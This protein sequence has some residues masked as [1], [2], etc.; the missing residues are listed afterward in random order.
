MTKLDSEQTLTQLECDNMTY[1]KKLILDI[2]IPNSVFKIKVEPF[3]KQETRV[4]MVTSD[5]P[6]FSSCKSYQFHK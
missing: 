4:K 1:I 2:I 5:C 6:A 3:L